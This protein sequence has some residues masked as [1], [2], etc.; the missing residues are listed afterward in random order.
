M[1]CF[2]FA[3]VHIIHKLPVNLSPTNQHVQ[4]LIANYRTLSALFV[5]SLHLRSQEYHDLLATTHFD[6]AMVMR[7]LVLSTG[8]LWIRQ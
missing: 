5:E 3:A 1:T 4:F 7:S 2:R 6:N 8:Q